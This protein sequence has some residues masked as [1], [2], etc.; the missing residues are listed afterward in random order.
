MLLEPFRVETVALEHV[1]GLAASARRYG[2][3][4]TRGVIDGWFGPG[5]Y[6]EADRYEWVWGG[7]W[8]CAGRC[9]PPGGRGGAAP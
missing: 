7:C 3:E 9:V 2:E 4:W 5:H 6:F 8:G 1:G